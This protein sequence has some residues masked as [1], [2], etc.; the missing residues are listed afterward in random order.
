MAAPPPPRA[1]WPAARGPSSPSW[2]PLRHPQKPAVCRRNG[3]R[4]RGPCA[5]G[6]AIRAS[7]LQTREV[8]PQRGHSLRQPSR[9]R[10]H[11]G[12]RW[13]SWPLPSVPRIR[14]ICRGKG[15]GSGGPCPLGAAMRSSA[16][17]L[18][19]RQKY[20]HNG[21]TAFADGLGWGRRWCPLRPSWLPRTPW[22][23]QKPDGARFMPFGAR[24]RRASQ[25]AGLPPT[26]CPLGL[27][28]AT[29]GRRSRAAQQSCKAKPWTPRTGIEIKRYERL[30]LQG[31]T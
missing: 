9:R 26:P 19:R 30:P 18:C 27:T 20:C 4:C 8:L 28:A 17:S 2:P 7:A 11:R 5:L 25:G 10:L 29:P 15:A 13:R 31:P 21:G 23:S 14:V 6:T 3:L 16:F 1:S 12:P 22:L 24:M